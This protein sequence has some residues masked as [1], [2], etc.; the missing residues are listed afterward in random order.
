[1]ALNREFQAIKH[2]SFSDICKSSKSPEDKKQDGN[3]SQTDKVEAG[4]EHDFGIDG[5]GPV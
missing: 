4:K 1:L 5:W 2:S 3:S